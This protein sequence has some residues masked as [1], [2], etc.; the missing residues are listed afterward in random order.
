MRRSYEAP[1]QGTIESNR[2]PSKT[3]AMSEG[4]NTAKVHVRR[5]VKHRAVLSSERAISRR[6]TGVDC[7]EMLALRRNHQYS[8]GSCGPNVAQFIHLHS[9]GHSFTPGH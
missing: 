6:L 9:V 7:A 4:L 8:A 1:L 3:S 5:D 2:A